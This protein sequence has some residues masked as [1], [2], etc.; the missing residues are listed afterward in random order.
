M[1]KL[2]S[3]SA[4]PT[5]AFFVR[6]LTRDITLTDCILDLIDNCIDGAWERAGGNAFTLN[7]NVELDQYKIDISLSEDGFT[8]SDNCGGIS[9]DDAVEYAFTFGRSAN[10]DAESYSIGIYGIGMKRAVFKIG[11]KILV[12]STSEANG[13]I[14]AFRVPI[15]VDRWL[16]HGDKEDWDFD[17]ESDNPLPEPGVQIS[18]DNLTDNTKADFSNPDFVKQL[19]RVISRDYSIHLHRGLQIS[20]NGMPVTG[21]LIELRESAEFTPMRDSYVDEVNGEE[22]F[23]EILAGMGAPPPD[24]LEPGERRKDFEQRSG[25]YVI[26]NGRVVVAADKSTITGWGT[27][28]WPKWHPQY[29]GFLGIVIFSAEN[30]ESLPLTTTKRSVDATQPMFRRALAQMRKPSTSWIEYT[31][32]RKSQRDAAYK[33]ESATNNISIFEIEHSKTAKLPSFTAKTRE[34]VAN[35]AYQMPK[36]RVRELA[37]AMGNV[38]LP[39]RDVGINTFELAFNELVG[40]D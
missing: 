40:E 23:V 35:I 20:V 17:I 22:V 6:M 37:A 24:D 38:G 26:C 32:A 15:D 5:R 1:K 16:A 36:N 29:S 7:N 10:A 25:W 30:A 31:N 8:I 33:S 11:R 9:F 12:R 2:G 14:E 39:Y 34:P 18:V 27:P 13:E 19:I 21:W 4:N 3:A 28:N